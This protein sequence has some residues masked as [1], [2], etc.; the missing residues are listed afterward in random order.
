LLHAVVRFVKK[1]L[2][3][4]VAVEF[5]DRGHRPTLKETQAALSRDATK[6]ILTRQPSPPSPQ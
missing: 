6:G 4:L 2:R 1:S 5:V 3:Q